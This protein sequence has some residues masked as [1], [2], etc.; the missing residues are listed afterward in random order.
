MGEMVPGRSRAGRLRATTDAVEAVLESDLSFVC[1]GTPSL[2]SGKLDL[3]HVEKVMGEDG[4]AL[5]RKKKPI[6]PWFC[7]AQFCRALR[8][9][10]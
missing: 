9:L 10:S 8:I 5:R 1:V 4:A 3:S 7:A 2:R 6:T